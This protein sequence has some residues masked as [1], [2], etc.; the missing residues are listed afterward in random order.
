MQWKRG[1]VVIA[2]R[3]FET[4]ELSAWKKGGLAIHRSVDTH[5]WTCT[6]EGTGFRLFEVGS[7]EVA[8]RGADAA[9]TLGDWTWTGPDGW[10]NSFS[11]FPEVGGW[12][13]Q[14]AD[15]YGFL[16]LSGKRGRLSLGSEEDRD[17]A[18][19]VAELLS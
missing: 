12:L 9:L 19:A 8:M 14:N 17:A 5:G 13:L 18:R 16:G 3:L 7:K 1:V 2:C 15:K 4:K 11:D 6:H 10:K